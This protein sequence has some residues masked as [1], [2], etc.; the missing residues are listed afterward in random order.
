MSLGLVRDNVTSCKCTKERSI[1]YQVVMGR[2]E[3]KTEKEMRGL[4]QGGYGGSG[5]DGGGG[6]GSSKMEE[7]DPHQ[8]PQLNLEKPAE[9]EEEE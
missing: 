2:V 8:R 5:S 4:Y 1:E 6:T 9:E 7:G 3:G